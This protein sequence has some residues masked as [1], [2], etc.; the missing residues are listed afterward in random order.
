MR[1]T[2]IG[3]G[4]LLGASLVAACGSDSSTDTGAIGTGGTQDSGAVLPEAG[5][6]YGLAVIN[7]QCGGG[8]GGV[9]DDCLTCTSTQCASQYGACFGDAWQASLAGG[10]CT[11]FGTCVMACDCGDNACFK[12][13]LQTVTADTASACY[14]CLTSLFSCEQTSCGDPCAAYL[15]SDAGA[16]QDGGGKPDSGKP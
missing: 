9:S 6:L 10:A 12:T 1:W 15:D 11:A 8:D 7:P 16:H 5:T 2:W 14:G 4:A 13:C 3:L